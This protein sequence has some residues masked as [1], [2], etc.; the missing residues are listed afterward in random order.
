MRE[1]KFRQAIF[2][3]GEFHSW[4]YWGYLDGSFI[5]PIDSFC[6]PSQQ[7][8]GLKDKNGK[9][10]YEGDILGGNLLCEVGWDDKYAGFCLYHPAFPNDKHDVEFWE[11]GQA[12]L[13]VIGSI[14]ENPELLNGE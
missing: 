11:L 2:I 12:E 3:N 14:Y 10:I 4:H 13:E 5:A 1:I 9:D 6:K 8:I 7:Y